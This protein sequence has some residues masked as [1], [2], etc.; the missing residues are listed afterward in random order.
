MIIITYKLHQHFISHRSGAQIDRCI[1]RLAGN[2]A[3]LSTSLSGSP[4]LL[5]GSDTQ[6]LQDQLASIVI[7]FQGAAERF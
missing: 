2:Y 3:P 1:R 6:L 4:A 7:P 5:F